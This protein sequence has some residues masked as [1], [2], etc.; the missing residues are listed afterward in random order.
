[1]ALPGI[2]F[3]N[4]FERL[5]EELF[6]NLFEKKVRPAGLLR[7]RAV[8]LAAISLSVGYHPEDF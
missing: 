1:M 5:F 4:L 6:E 7:R 8:A 2:F 3:K